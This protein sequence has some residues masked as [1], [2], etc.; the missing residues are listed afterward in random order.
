LA[1]SGRRSADRA[2][3]LVIA[4]VQ[5]TCTKAEIASR[6]RALIGISEDCDGGLLVGSFPHSLWI[7]G[8][9]LGLHLVLDT[10][11]AGAST[12]RGRSGDPRAVR[13]H[14]ELGNR[15]PRD[16]RGGSPLPVAGDDPPAVA[17]Q[18]VGEVPDGFHPE[19]AI[20]TSDQ[21]FC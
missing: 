14:P 18:F 5:K 2:S 10:L 7:C 16:R 21:F 17:R 19:L 3:T 13:C 9:D 8:R 20:N 15:L 6:A 4:D 1:L 11:N 12:D